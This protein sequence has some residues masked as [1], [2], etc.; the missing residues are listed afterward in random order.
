[1]TYAHVSTWDDGGTG[2]DFWISAFAGMTAHPIRWGGCSGD[3]DY[4]AAGAA[5]GK[6][7]VGF[8]DLGHGQHLVND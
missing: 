2:G 7:L 8:A 4:L 1:M 6:V 5:V 3:E